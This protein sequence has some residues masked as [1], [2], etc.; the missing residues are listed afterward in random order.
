MD[1]KGDKSSVQDE[2]VQFVDLVNTN[3]PFRMNP[4]TMLALWAYRSSSKDEIH[5]FC[6][7]VISHFLK[8]SSV[9]WTR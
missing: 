9:I 7:L 2:P 6:G 5:P 4:S 1:F 3:H 8:I